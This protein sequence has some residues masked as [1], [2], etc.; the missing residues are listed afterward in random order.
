MGPL[1][2]HD[3]GAL[4]PGNWADLAL[5][6]LEAITDATYE[7]PKT[8]PQGIPHVMVNG[9]W[10]IRDGRFTGSLPGEVLRR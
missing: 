5:F 10:V 6:D 1:N 9:R 4:T 2:T 8:Y 7:R 3:R